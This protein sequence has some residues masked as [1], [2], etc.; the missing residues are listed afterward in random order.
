MLEDDSA[1]LAAKPLDSNYL[2][3]S[4]T[5]SVLLK[6]ISSGNDGT[7][8]S[9]SFLPSNGVRNPQEKD[10]LFHA[11]YI[12]SRFRPDLIS[13]EIKTKSVPDVCNYLS[14]PTTR[15]IPT[16]KHRFVFSTAAKSSN[17]DGG[18]LGMDRNG[19]GNGFR[20]HAR[21]GFVARTHRR[22]ETHRTQVAKRTFQ[23]WAARHGTEP[24]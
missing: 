14:V 13:H 19:G 16:G 9:P 21:A 22:T 7:P 12:Y 2:R 24:A 5:T 6:I 3:V 23:D 4:W 10:A 15:C 11:L 18:L 8:L 20:R 1:D 17:R